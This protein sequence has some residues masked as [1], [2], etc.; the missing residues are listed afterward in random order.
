MT[1]E[2]VDDE[3]LIDFGLRKKNVDK[4]TYRDILKNC[5]MQ[6]LWTKGTFNYKNNVMALE[7]A[8]YIDIKGYRLRKVIEKIKQDL[9]HQK[10]NLIIVE[11]KRL[12]RNF[13]GNVE[14]VTFKIKMQR[15]Y[16]DSLFSRL[17]QLI[18][19]EGLLLETE[20]VIKVRMKQPLGEDED[21]NPEGTI[22]DLYR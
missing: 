4:V 16:W 2:T 21:G 1:T 9:Q 11:R 18:A 3:E 14:Q 8:I 17:Y 20:K 13:Y 15:W 6:C 19:E 5:I 10:K 12:G 7:D 22:G